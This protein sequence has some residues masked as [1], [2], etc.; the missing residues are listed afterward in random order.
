MRKKLLQSVLLAAMSA[1]MLCAGAMAAPTEV[2]IDTGYIGP[3]DDITGAPTSSTVGDTADGRVWVNDTV[4]FDTNE[5]MYIY[6]VGSSIYTAVRASVMD[7]MVTNDPVSVQADEGVALTLFRNGEE[8]TAPNL[9]QISAP[10]K[11]VVMN[12]TGAQTGETLFSFTIV[13]VKSNLVKNYRMPS[14]FQIEAVTL[15]GE[16]TY[17]ER[18]Y[19]DL[20]VEGEYYIKTRCMR[21]DDVYELRYVADFTPPTLALEAVVDGVAKGPVSLTD[22]EKGCGIG[23]WLNDEPIGYSEE[24]TQSGNYVVK[25]ADEAGNLTTYNFTIQIYFDGNSIVFFAI[26]VGVVLATIGYIIVSRKRLRVR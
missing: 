4:Q 17:F 8:Q 23:I 24:L 14:G 20:S 19:V 6:S 9:Q 3:L 16:D 26:I 13:G 1:A 11:Y 21:T 5:R 10:G 18:N 2:G 22:L 25:V 15:N 7:G 12:A